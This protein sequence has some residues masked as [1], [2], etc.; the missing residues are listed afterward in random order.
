MKDFRP[1]PKSQRHRQKCLSLLV[2]L[3]R[4]MAISKMPLPRQVVT[5]LLIPSACLIRKPSATRLSILHSG[6]QIPLGRKDHRG[7]VKMTTP[8]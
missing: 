4:C 2:F 8:T 7:V 1:V 5:C 3:H 6:R